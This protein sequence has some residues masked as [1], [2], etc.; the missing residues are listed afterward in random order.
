MRGLRAALPERRIVDVRFGKMDF[1]ED[2]AA[3]AERLPGTR[4]AGVSRLGKFISVEL[5]PRAK[6]AR[7]R[8]RLS[9]L[10]HLGMTGQLTIAEAG[11]PVPRHTH[12]QIALDDG[13]ELRYT[14]IRRFGRIRL[15]AEASL[16]DLKKRL[17]GEPLEVSAEEFCRHL[18]SRRARVKALLL[19]QRVLRGIGNIYADESLFVARLHPARIAQNLKKQQLLS[20]H[21]AIRLVLAEAIRLRGSSISDYVDSEGNRGEYH[22]RHQVY[23]REGEPCFR[24][25]AKIRRIIVAGRSSHYCPRC[26]PAPR[27][28]RRTKPRRRTDSRG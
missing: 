22:L 3:I 4:I 1:V 13:R 25:G 2:P 16:E 28:R 15:A 19:D 10:I 5:E 21:S 7:S 27:N 23:Q 17:G 18:S 11:N 26:Q 20:L 6:G 8:P 24:C 9:L 14:D 12:C